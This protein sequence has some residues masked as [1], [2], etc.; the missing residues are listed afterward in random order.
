NYRKS[1]NWRAIICLRLHELLLVCASCIESRECLIF[2]FHHSGKQATPEVG[3]KKRCIDG[4]QPHV[5]KGSEGGF[6]CGDI[7]LR[8]RADEPYVSNA[9]QCLRVLRANLIDRL[10]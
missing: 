10:V 8:Q 3:G 9:L 6:G 7:T 4:K 5:T 1:A 2:V